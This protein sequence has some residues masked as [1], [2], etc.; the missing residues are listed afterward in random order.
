MLTLVQELRELESKEKYAYNNIHRFHGRPFITV[1][2][3]DKR[4]DY[5]IKSTKN[6]LKCHIK[7]ILFKQ[8]PIDIISI[9]IKYI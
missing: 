7:L 2:E 1:E 9:I 3:L 6:L 8:F 4:G 5:W